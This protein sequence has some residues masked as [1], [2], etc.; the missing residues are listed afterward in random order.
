M[1]PVPVGVPGELYIGGV[2]LAREY[3]NHPTLTAEKFVRNPF[4]S[5]P[6]ARLYRTGDF[7]RWRPDGCIEY[8]GRMDHQVKIRGFR[9]ELG[10]VEASCRQ[11]PAVRDA[12]VIARENAAKNV[13]LPTLYRMTGRHRHSATS[14]STCKR[15]YPITWCRRR[16]LEDDSGNPQWQGGPPCVAAAQGWSAGDGASV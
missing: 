11:H 6:R 7:V 14:A 12:V 5:E 9:I 10:E 15:S 1:N 4:S 2:G 13:W 8:L 3:L 16:N